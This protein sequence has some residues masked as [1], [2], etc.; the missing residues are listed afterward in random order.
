MLAE[1][2]VAKRRERHRCSGMSRLG[3]LHRVHGQ[4]AHGVDG[5]LLE[6]QRGGRR[7]LCHCGISGVCG[8]RRT[9]GWCSPKL[10]PLAQECRSGRRVRDGASPL[11]LGYR[12]TD[13]IMRVLMHHYSRHAPRAGALGHAH[14]PRALC[15]AIVASALVVAGCAAPPAEEPATTADAAAPA[16]APAAAT[17]PADV[18]TVADTVSMTVYK[19]PTCG[20][21]T[22][23]VEHME[24]HGIRVDAR[25]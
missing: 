2:R 11:S 15:A 16:G 18:A 22:K 6:G 9:A 19:E 4:R 10:A 1:E 12:N 20:C 13:P 14:R 7:A 24:Q 8:S 23:W 17:T 5:K 3:L 21:C 25:N